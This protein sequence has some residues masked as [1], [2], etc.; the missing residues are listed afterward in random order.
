MN[1]YKIAI[2]SSDNGSGLEDDNILKKSFEKDGHAVDINRVD[3]DEN[4]DETYDVIIRRNTWVNS[5][6]ETVEL[7]ENNKK[8][9]NRLQNK[10]VKTVNLVG[11]DGMGKGYLCDMFANGEQVIPT[12]NTM[13]NVDLLPKSEKYVI[14]NIKSFGN[15][16]FQKFV[17]ANELQNEYTEGE[18]IQPYMDFVSEVQCYYVGEELMYV[19]EYTPSKYPNYPPPHFIDLTENEKILSDKY[20]KYTNLKHGFQRIDFLRKPDN[21]LILMEIEDHAAFMNLRRLPE[22]ILEKT[23]TKYKENIYQLLA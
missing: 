22:D 13:T 16:L 18:I 14:K 6:D 1:K 21:S 15:G 17:D 20:A 12:I 5:T 8:L 10:D 11:L 19:F 3:Y 4:L 9:I 23:L 7:Y 2:L